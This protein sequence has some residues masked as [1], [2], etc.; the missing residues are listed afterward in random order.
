ML[1]DLL[2]KL[3][4]LSILDDD[5]I[6]MYSIAIMANYSEVNFEQEN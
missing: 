3:A 6:L 1:R 5:Q 4:D 2:G